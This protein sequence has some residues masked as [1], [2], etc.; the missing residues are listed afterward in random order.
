MST[1]QNETRDQRTVTTLAATLDR[2]TKYQEL[3]D[4]EKDKVSGW[5][6]SFFREDKL[7]QL[8]HRTRWTSQVTLTIIQDKVGDLD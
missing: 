1:P 8:S 5:L 2:Q 6:H 4:K 7:V 3:I